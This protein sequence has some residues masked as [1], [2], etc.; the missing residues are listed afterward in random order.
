[1]WVKLDVLSFLLENVVGLS[2]EKTFLRNMALGKHG[3]KRGKKK[4]TT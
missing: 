2:L 3:K 4:I 1:M